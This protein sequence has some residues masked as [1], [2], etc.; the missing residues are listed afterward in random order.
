MPPSES[1][2]HK[3]DRVR[4]PRVHLT[5][6]VEID[7]AL[8][9]KELPFVVG[10]LADLAGNRPEKPLPP[11][12]NRDFVAIDRDNFD[13]VM[14]GIKP[15]LVI[16]VDNAVQGN[17]S[18]LNLELCFSRMTDFEPGQVARQVKPL[19]ELLAERDRLA[20]LLHK[21]DGNDQLEDVLQQVIH[22]SDALRR[23]S[24]ETGRTTTPNGEE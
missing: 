20:N 12:K 21:L 19:R 1:L 3:L 16:Q 2:Q 18:K 6:D 7:G 9:E 23:L 22:N 13:A 11:A 10:V 8:V 4:K 5:Y 24:L 15:R 17:G 14:A